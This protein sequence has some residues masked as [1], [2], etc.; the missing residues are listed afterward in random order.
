MNHVIKRLE[1][2]MEQLLLEL[3][4]LGIA[5]SRSIMDMIGFG[6]IF[7]DIL[8]YSE[9]DTAKKEA[10]HA[11]RIIIDVEVENMQV[12]IPGINHTRLWAAFDILFDRLSS[13]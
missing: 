1:K 9:F 6:G 2:A 13:I 10:E 4:A 5:D 3:E 7:A 8:E 12:G 11:S